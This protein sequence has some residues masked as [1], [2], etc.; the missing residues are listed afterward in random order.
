MKESAQAA[1]SYVRSTAKTIGIR[2]EVFSQTD[3]HIHVPA[4]AIPKDGPSAGITMAAAITSSLTNIPAKHEVAMTGEVTLRGRVLPIG[5]LKEKILAAKRASLS[6]VILPKRNEK[7]LEELP[8]H[9]LRGLRFIFAETMADVIPTALHLPAKLKAQLPSLGKRASASGKKARTAPVSIPII[10]S[11]DKQETP[12]SLWGLT[13]ILT[14]RVRGIASENSTLF[15][16][17]ETATVPTNSSILQGIG[18]DCRGLFALDPVK[19]FLSPQMCCVKIFILMSRLRHWLKSDTR[20]PW[21]ISAILR[22]WVDNRSM[23]FRRWP[24]PLPILPQI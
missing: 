8:K 11:F 24:F 22:P 19:I 9:L 10:C 7:D 16:N 12:V 13:C 23:L 3:M 4:G 1:L 2:Q 18:D 5:G 15:N 20:P 14:F 6:T 17:S 21:P